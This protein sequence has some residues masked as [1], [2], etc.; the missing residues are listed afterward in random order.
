MMQLPLLL[1]SCVPLSK[2]AL[3]ADGCT[4]PPP[5]AVMAVPPPMAPNGFVPARHRFSTAL[6]NYGDRFPNHR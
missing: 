3:E 6:P 2:P 5:F 4:P 1:T